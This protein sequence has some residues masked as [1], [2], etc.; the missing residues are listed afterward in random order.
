MIGVGLALFLNQNFKGR[1]LIR[2]LLILPWALPG[3]VN[4]SMWSWIYNANF[5]ALNALLHQSGFISE[6]K[7]WLADPTVAMILVILANVW[8]ETPFTAI[9]VLAALQGIPAPLYEAAQIDG[10]TNFQKFFRITLPIITSVIMICGL[11]QIIWS[12]LHTFELIYVIT[13]GGQFNATDIIPIRIYWQTFKSLRFGYGTAMAYLTSFILLNSR[14]F[15]HS[16]SLQ[17]RS[18]VLRCGINIIF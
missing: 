8:K 7:A 4:A 12:L 18:G 1:G 13:R 17:A 2:G 10:V 9:M 5:G 15:L 3:V 6:Y 11:L 16:L 14:F